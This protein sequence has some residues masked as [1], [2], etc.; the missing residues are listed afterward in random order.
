MFKVPSL[1]KL[2][3]LNLISKTDIITANECFKNKTDIAGFSAN[4]KETIFCSSRIINKITQ[5]E[6]F[7]FNSNS[8]FSL[9]STSSKFN[10]N[11]IKN[12]ESIDFNSNS[13]SSLSNTKKPLSKKDKI[14]QLLDEKLEHENK[15]RSL[16]YETSKTVFDMSEK[17]HPSSKDIKI[18]LLQK[19]ISASKLSNDRNRIIYVDSTPK[20]IPIQVPKKSNDPNKIKIIKSDGPL[21]R[22]KGFSKKHLFDIF[23]DETSPPTKNEHLPT[24]IRLYN[25]ANELKLIG[26]T[27]PTTV[28]SFKEVISAS[29]RKK[30]NPMNN[31]KFDSLVFSDLKNKSKDRLLV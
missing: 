22:A 5:T 23:L 17:Y 11:Q 14:I 16:K 25:K 4:S 24:I 20:S 27:N 6:L 1:N 7:D 13:K 29:H 9:T 30:I 8:K 12:D 2:N 18:S 3:K 28:A 19:K 31:F 21:T 15:I 10:N 26:K